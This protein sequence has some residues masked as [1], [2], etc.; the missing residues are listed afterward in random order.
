VSFWEKQSVTSASKSV[1]MRTL[2]KKKGI[3]SRL[4]PRMNTRPPII[5]YNI[6][7]R[8]PIMKVFGSA[9]GFGRSIGGF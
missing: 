2:G 4:F 9:C 7:I 1:Y 8:N 6:A 5:T 3:K